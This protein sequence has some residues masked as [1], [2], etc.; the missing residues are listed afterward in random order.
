MSQPP[1]W[2]EDDRDGTLGDDRF[3][4]ATYHP[5]SVEELR[6]NVREAV[7]SGLAV[8]PQGGGTSLNHGG[9]PDRP[10]V[11]VRL[12]RLGR[13]IDYPFADMTV[14]VEAGMT[15]GALRELVSGQG[16]KLAIE[17]SHPESATLGGIFATATTGPRRFGWGRPRDQI[18]GVGFV[19]GGGEL[20]R[21][22]GR[23][24]KNVA[25]YDFPKLLTGS[26]GTLGIITELTLKVSPRPEASALVRVEFDTLDL[27]ASALDRLNI[28]GTRPV[29][30]EIVDGLTARSRQG[31]RWELLLG[32][33][34][35]EA[36]VLWQIHRL[37]SEL[38]QTDLRIVRDSDAESSWLDFV[39][40]EANTTGPIRFASSFAPSKALRFLTTVDLDR[41]SIR[42]HAGNGVVRG[43]ARS[44]GDLETWASEVDRLR[45]E[46]A[47]LDGA[48]ILPRCPTS[49][50]GRLKV[51]GL[52]RP[53]WSIAERVKLALD[54]GRVLNP[55]RFL[56][57]IES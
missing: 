39:E 36:A 44:E 22:G 18:I 38:G 4:S 34:G 53:D 29:A 16:Q 50:K 30:L 28:S 32:L 35:N 48:L 6:A 21:G 41:W 7:A 42:V 47:R 55:G 5:E 2:P 24:V 51:W 15:L 56:D 1:I 23:V 20:V 45:L 17:A 26:M 3:A 14:T 46:A 52:R 19:T 54:P 37:Q 57:T 25:G 31:V 10:G 9:I 40:N 13:L 49:W 27:A 33:E 12:D 8:Y 11:A 43:A